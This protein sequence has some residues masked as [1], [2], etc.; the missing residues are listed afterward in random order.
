M[1]L[2]PSLQSL[3]LLAAPLGSTKHNS[4]SPRFVPPRKSSA[5]STSA[6]LAATPILL[7]PL[8]VKVFAI[9]QWIFP[10]RAF[11]RK[12]RLSKGFPLLTCFF[13]FV[14]PSLHA[15]AAPSPESHAASPSSLSLV[16][17]PP[18]PSPMQAWSSFHP[19]IKMN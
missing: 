15:V 9:C 2:L 11:S 16:Q 18:R 4:Y 17:K 14:G 8:F 7:G 10:L 5:S 19:T 3:A 6:S 13:L 12:L 1:F